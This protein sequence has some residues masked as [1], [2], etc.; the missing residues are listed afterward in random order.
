MPDQAEFPIRLREGFKGQVQ[1]V[2]PRPVL[3]SIAGHPLLHSLLPTDIGWYPQAQYHFRERPDGADEHILIYCVAGGGWAEFGKTTV[4]I[5]PGDALL[6]PAHTPHTYG[7]A[8]TDPW[9]IHWVHFLGDEGA[10]LARLLKEP[11]CTLAVEPGCGVVVSALFQ[12]CYEVF[13]GGFVLTRLIY[14]AKLLH[15][16]LGE[17]FFN[18]G[19]FSPSL[20]SSRFHSVEST[21]TFLRSN[22]HR[23][24]SLAE[25]AGQAGLSES[26]FSRVFKAQTGHAPLDYFILLKMQHASALLA[27]TDLHVKEV[28][29]AVGYSDP[30]YFSRLFKQVI[31]VSPRDYRRAPKG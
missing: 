13:L 30:Y 4:S 20:R 14:A 29:A 26:H 23:P 27:V 17:L 3:A 24:L 31:G 25:M 10:Y 7:A 6:I 5:T 1:Y 18:N 12:A 8:M 21:L 19:A 2:I 16:L 9:S 28:A 15:R 22:L 11:T